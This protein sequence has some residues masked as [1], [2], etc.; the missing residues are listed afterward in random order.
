MTY[1]R[2]LMPSGPPP[3][4]AR[5]VACR[6]TRMIVGDLAE[7]LDCPARWYG[8][9]GIG[10]VHVIGGRRVNA[11]PRDRAWISGECADGVCGICPRLPLTAGLP[12]CSHPC[13]DKKTED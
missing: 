8:V 5:P 3:A 6:C 9:E 1:P 13:H 12:P 11:P 7:T 2:D 10:W 4:P